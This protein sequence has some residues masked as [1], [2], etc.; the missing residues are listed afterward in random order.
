ML[1]SQSNWLAGLRGRLAAV[2]R[3]ALSNYIGQSLIGTFIFYG[4]GLGLFGTFSRV[5]QFALIL[6]IWAAQIGFSTWWLRRFQYG[7]LEWVWRVLSH[8]HWQPL[9]KKEMAAV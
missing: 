3:M 8:W 7:P 5:Q 4:W 9:R 1:W 6:L 2:G